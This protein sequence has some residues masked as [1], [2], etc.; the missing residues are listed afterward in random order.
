MANSFDLIEFLWVSWMFWGLSCKDSLKIYKKKQE[1]ILKY[2][3]LDNYA[4]VFAIVR[5]ERK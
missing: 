5:E 4:I 3:K 2:K 1:K